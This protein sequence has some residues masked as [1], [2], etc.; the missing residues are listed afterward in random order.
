M[1]PSSGGVYEAH[2]ST[3]TGGNSFSMTYEH[4]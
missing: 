1:D 4:E 2:A 3:L